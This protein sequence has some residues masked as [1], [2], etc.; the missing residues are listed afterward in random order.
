ADLAAAEAKYS[1]AMATMNRALSQNDGTLAGTERVKVDYFKA[2]LTRA[3]ERLDRTTLRA[4]FDGV[5]TTPQ[6]QNSVGRRLVHGDTFA[7]VVET[8]HVTVDIAVPEDDASLL[9][10]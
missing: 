3:R 2:E 8:S 7:E 6:V 1:E 4:P 10:S 9:R 5:V